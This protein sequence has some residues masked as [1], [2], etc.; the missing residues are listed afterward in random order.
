[1]NPVSHINVL[2]GNGS[3]NPFSST[4]SRLNEI[5]NDVPGFQGTNGT[6]FILLIADCACRH[7]TILFQAAIIV[8]F[9][10]EV[11]YYRKIENARA[12]LVGLVNGHFKLLRLG[13]VFGFYITEGG[14]KSKLRGISLTSNLLYQ[15]PLL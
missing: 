4:V 2:R 9:N 3:K 13:T 6:N 10:G 8:H 11:I 7:Q 15:A 14:K 1:M 5:K 12:I